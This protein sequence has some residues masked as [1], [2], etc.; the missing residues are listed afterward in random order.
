MTRSTRS[1]T[2][3]LQIGLEATTFVLIRQMLKV[4]FEAVEVFW[5]VCGSY[6]PCA[7]I[8]MPSRP[9]HRHGK[10]GNFGS[11]FFFVHFPPFLKSLVPRLK[12]YKFCDAAEHDREICLNPAV[13]SER[14]L[15][16]KLLCCL[17][18]DSWSLDF[19]ACQ[20]RCPDLLNLL[21]R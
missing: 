20:M 6:S 9:P 14:R 12:K 11:L 3:L 1:T 21:T 10:P 15:L 7:D 19:S 2:E 17:F 5:P 16:S 4:A 13:A 8:S 18:V